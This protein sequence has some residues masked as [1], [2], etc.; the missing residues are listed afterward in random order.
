M[1][2]NKKAKPAENKTQ[3]VK[4][5]DSY[6]IKKNLPEKNKMTNTIKN[7]ASQTP[8]LNQANTTRDDLF[9]SDGDNLTK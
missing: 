5:S 4:E 6:R 3:T 1:K 2:K 7:T 9:P 8:G